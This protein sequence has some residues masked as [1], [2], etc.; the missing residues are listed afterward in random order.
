[1]SDTGWR[2]RNLRH[3][4]D[5]PFGASGWTWTRGEERP[6]ARIGADAQHGRRD[7][8]SAWCVVP[9]VP[10]NPLVDRAATAEGL[11]MRDMPPARTSPG[12]GDQ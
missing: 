10:G 9:D 5:P 3:V 2:A 4:T 1:L 11:A 6:A 12:R 7:A 8:T